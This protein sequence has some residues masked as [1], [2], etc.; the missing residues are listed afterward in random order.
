GDPSPQSRAALLR[1]VRAVRLLLG[2]DV[3]DAD[4][5][6]TLIRGA[7][8]VVNMWHADPDLGP[9]GPFSHDLLRRVIAAHPEA[10]S[11]V[12]RDVTRRVLAAAA[13]AWQS[14]PSVPVSGFVDLPVLESA[15]RWL[16]D[17]AAV[18]TAAVTALKLSGPDEV[19]AAARARMFWA[20]V[21]AEET[22]LAAQDADALTTRVLHLDPAAEVDEAL[23]GEALTLLTRGFAAGRNMADVDVAAAYDLETRGAFDHASA[24]TTM[25]SALGDGRDWKDGAAVLLPGL[26]T[27]RVPSGVVAAPWAGQDASGTAKPVPY[28]VRASVDLQDG[29]D[30]HVTF[31]GATY[32]VRAAEL[33]E[34]LASDPELR[35]KDLTTPVLLILDGLDGPA[36]GVADLVAQRLGRSVWWSPFPVELSGTDDAGVTVP[37]LVGS[38]M[39]LTSPTAADWREARPVDRGGVQEGRRPVD[40]PLPAAPPSATAFV[41]TGEE[42]TGAAAATASS[43]KARSSAGDPMQGVET[44]SDAMEGVE[45]TSA[46]VTTTPVHTAPAAP[47]PPA[48]PTRSLVAYAN[49]I[50]TPSAEGTETLRLL[51]SQVAAAG[52]RNQR[53]GASLPRVAVTGYG[54]DARRDEQAAAARRR[55][56]TARTLFRRLLARAL[57]DLQQDLPAGGPRLTVEDFTVGA[58]SMAR[59]PEDWVGTGPLDGVTRAELGRQATIGITQPPDAAAMQTLE[60]LRRRDRSLRDRPLDVDALARRVLHLDPG[61][62]VGPDRSAELFALVQR[63]TAVGA[64]TSLAALGAFHLAELGVRDP[65][66][67]RHFTVQGRRVPGLNWDDD[68]VAELDTTSGDVL[69]DNPSG[70]YDILDTVGTPWPQGVTPYVVAAA[71]AHDR[72]EVR[73]PDGSTRELD[74]DEFVE[75]VAADVA[76][77]TLAQGTPLVLAVPFA[78]DAYLDLPRKLADRTGR[79]VWAHSGEVTL[80]SAPGAASTIDI[81]RR[82]GVPQGDWIASVPGLAPDPDDDA[83]A[84]HREVVTRPIVSSLTGKQIGRASHHPAEYAEHFEQEGRHF[85]R[86]TTFV[87]HY[88]ATGGTSREHDLPRPGPEDT[89]YRLDMH[90]EP[91]VL[92]LAMRDGGVRLVDERE[93]GPWLKRRKS[94]A[95][96]PDDHWI[97]M[98][99]CWSGAPKGSAVPAPGT[100][101]DA[102][103]GPFVPDPLRD[104]SMG[105]HL[106]NSTGRTVR[107]AYSSQGARSAGG[108]YMRTLYADAQGRHRAWDLFRPEPSGPALD[109]L[110]E[111]AGYRTGAGPVTDEARERTLRLVRA[112]RLTF[113][114]EVDDAPDFGDLL[115]GAAA[116]DHM[117]SSDSDF[118]AAGPF[119]LDLLRRVTEAHAGDSAAVD[120]AATRRALTAA[121]EQWSMWP[122]DVLVGFVDLPAVEAAAQWMRD[123]DP[124]DEAATA[125]DIDPDEVG[126]TERSRIFWARV[127]AEE[128]LLDTDPDQH[129]FIAQVLHLPPGARTG[130]AERDEALDLVT[131]AFAVGRDASDPDVAAAYALE[132]SGAYTT[133]RLRTVQDGVHGG[134]RDFT[135]VPMPSDVDLARFRTPAGVLDAPWKQG[136]DTPVPY[137]VRV[138][139]DP[140][141]PDLL[142][143]SYDG[144][145]SSVPTAEFAEVL[146]NDLLLMRRE[147]TTPV[148]LAFSGPPADA[149]DVAHRLAQRLGRSVWWTD[150]PADLSA[151]GGSGQP[152]LDLRDSTVAGSVPT[153]DVWHETR[154]VRYTSAGDAPRT[155]PAPVPRSTGR[156]TRSPAPSESPSTGSLPSAGAVDAASDPLLSEATLLT[157]AQG[158]PRGR[159]WTGTGVGIVDPAR[160]RLQE[161]R[162]GELRTV[163]EGASPWGE[164]AYVVAAEAGY[165]E[166]LFADGRELG[167]QALAD[168][169]AADPVLDSLPRDVPVVLVS[170]YAGAQYGPLARAAAERLGRRVWAPSGDGRVTGAEDGPGATATGPVASVPSLVDSDPDDAYGDWVPFD[171]PSDGSVRAEDRE[172][173]TVDGVRFRDSDVETRPLVGADHRFEGRESMPD[174]GRRRLRERRL[175]LYRGMRERTHVVRVGDAFHTVGAEETAPD[176][177]ASVYTFHAH[178]VPG[179]LKLA[180]RDGR[181]LLL[182]AEDGGRYIGG[183]PEVVARA[184]GDALHVASCYGAVAGDPLRS[185]SLIRPAPLVEDPLEEV[186]LAQ[187]AANH[188]GRTTTAATG[189][190]GYND[191]VRL[192][193]ATPDGTLARMETFLPEP[194]GATAELAEAAGLRPLPRPA[195]LPA[196]DDEAPRALRL[197]RALRLVFGNDVEAD[198]GVPGGRHERLLRGIGALETLRANDP[199]LSGYTPLRMELWQLLVP[200]PDGGAAPGPADFEAVLDRALAAPGDAA[201][202][203]VWDVPALRAASDRLTD[204]GDGA[205]RPVLRMPTGPLTRRA[206]ARALWAMTGAARLLDTASPAEREERG[207]AVLHLPAGTAW[208]AAAE[209][210]LRELTEQAFAA[211]RTSGHPD[212]LAVFHLETMGAFAEG[213]RMRAPGGPLQGRDWGPAPTPGGPES[214]RPFTAW[215]GTAPDTGSPES[216][217][218]AQEGAVAPYFVHA[219]TDT[220]GAVVLHLPDGTAQVTVREFYALLESDPELPLIGRHR[221]VVLLVPGL[222]SGELRDQQHFSLTNDRTVWSHDGA[223]AVSEDGATQPEAR[224][225]GVWRRT[226]PQLPPLGQPATADAVRDPEWNAGTATDP[227]TGA[228]AAGPA[229]RPGPYSADGR[230]D[231]RFAETLEAF[232]VAA[233]TDRH[234]VW[235][236]GQEDPE[237]H[238]FVAEIPSLGVR[239]EYTPDGPSAGG[240]T[241]MAGRVYSDGP[242]WDWYLPGRG[243]VASSRLLTEPHMATEDGPPPVPVVWPATGPVSSAPPVDPAT[244]AADPAALAGSKLP[245]AL[246]RDHDGPLFRF[247]PDGPERV[248]GVGLRAYGPDMVH[249]LDHVYGGSSLVPTTVFASTTANRHYVRDSARANP[250]GAHALYHRYR[251]RYDIQVPGG[252]DVNATLGLASPFPDQEEVLFPGGIDR[253]YIR[254]AQPMEYGM[255]LGPYVANPHFAPAAPSDAAAKADGPGAADVGGARG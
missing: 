120:Q 49:G 4:D 254:G 107:L 170:P 205:V 23:R 16:G 95:S 183:L 142:R 247:S 187:H 225:P 215:T 213:S 188:S 52:L 233:S 199:A 167:P 92:Q 118:D 237:F 211:G 129:E 206:Y 168:L 28:L 212:E 153:A 223:P 124:V 51:A 158:A 56:Q 68:T 27:F 163:S 194:V 222:G 44:D 136:T 91:G 71:G 116:V 178:G 110:A 252:I 20:R 85:D 93:A 83:P 135:G 78:A 82:P 151:A 89:A 239:G 106:A 228:A 58:R 139:P 229:G 243:L 201:L 132:E 114:H 147:L 226:V 157:D 216:A 40:P 100:V 111:A 208:D 122:G 198:R 45:P 238:V 14:G 109:R 146:A 202:T 123:G 62:G 57:D 184:A 169:L 103:P 191:S 248:F 236:F 81:V 69:E 133:T 160:I 224:G 98:V 90:G 1:L 221:P 119:T 26:D 155:L 41:D 113:G 37:T 165:D 193:A 156:G 246:W 138:A 234:T 84:W 218:W 130:R 21:K 70:T 29:N 2:Q 60:D 209:A 86:M 179:G 31:D 36:P 220:A 251:W 104:V 240:V 66:R 164:T 32:Q 219:E 79:T 64:A 140:H 38:L 18:D 204:G 235:G 152:V 242:A 127:K 48:L 47:S 50:T 74:V 59:P 217:P 177:E 244:V 145:M 126:T 87:H 101:S 207:R 144:E 105:Q 231:E 180:G 12:D 46:S 154:P 72:V 80:S 148:V 203:A 3:E 112:L 176:P 227:D 174:D 175:R 141:D 134:G 75:L 137:L 241:D 96:L 150:F 232:P 11:G 173:V 5:F 10:A 35:R 43:G 54:A 22:L 76:G 7:A 182:G 61:A 53:A 77:E 63:A 149:G 117:W 200:A 159:D 99:V 171:P 162:G 230:F 67:A 25:G 121:A 253:R 210:R 185:Q 250:M 131:R 102:F 245:D 55:A 161:Q 94:L 108:R 6:T 166:A 8:A 39:T 192:L 73:L 196:W 186:A 115:R 30:L 9:T 214:P 143:L 19:D 125:L 42:T 128:T 97:D 189:R 249:L 197:T 24:A 190:T 255:P 17:T 34:L 181:V 33:A 13:Q 88:P 195:G 15:A 172:W 65:G